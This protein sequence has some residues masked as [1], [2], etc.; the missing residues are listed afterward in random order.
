MSQEFLKAGRDIRESGCRNLQSGLKEFHGIV[1]S[2]IRANQEAIS[3]LNSGAREL[4]GRAASF[5]NEILRYQEQDL[6]NY[7]RDFYYG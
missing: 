4:Q 7:V 3:R 1:N 5:Q 2:Q 6:K